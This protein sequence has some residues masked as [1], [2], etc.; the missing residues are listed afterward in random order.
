MQFSYPHTVF[1]NRSMSL[2]SSQNLISLDILGEVISSPYTSC[3][4]SIL[5]PLLHTNM[6]HQDGLQGSGPDYKC[7]WSN[8][9]QSLVDPKSLY[10]HLRNDHIGKKTTGILSLICRW[11]GC[12]TS[13]TNRVHIISHLIG[14]SSGLLLC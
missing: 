5:L 13:C 12:S 10:N 8:C 4:H 14:V 1:C 9:I 11:K 3:N 7:I 2:F 6:R